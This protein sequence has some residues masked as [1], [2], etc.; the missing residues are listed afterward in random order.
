[1]MPLDHQP[2]SPLPLDGPHPEANGLVHGPP[3][4]LPAALS[5]QIN[6]TLGS[7][8]H[9]LVRI[10]RLPAKRWRDCRRLR[11]EALKNDPAAFSSSYEEEK[12]LTIEEWR[13]RT[14]NTLFAFAD[15]TPVGSVGY[16]FNTKKKTRHVAGIFGVYVTAGHRGQGIGRMLVEGA[17]SR[18]RGKKRI[19]K[20]QL[21][22]NPELRPALELYK[23]CGFVVTGRATKELRIGPRFYDLL[24]MEKEI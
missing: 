5:P 9:S 19:L 22:V 7:L 1:M 20:V 4:S 3:G 15:G 24:Y 11:L 18:I 16:Y 8:P 14:R 2:S 21:S 6:R 10:G 13:R 23:N 12:L 17:L